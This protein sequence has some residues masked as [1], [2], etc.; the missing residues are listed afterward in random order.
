MPGSSPLKPHDVLPHAVEGLIGSGPSTLEALTMVT[1]TAAKVCG[2]ADRKGHIRVGAHADLL[3]VSGDP[4][5]D[6]SHLRDIR[7]VYRAG[8]KVT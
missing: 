6:L 4:L 8:I 3:A 7:A 2:V 1:S 5:S